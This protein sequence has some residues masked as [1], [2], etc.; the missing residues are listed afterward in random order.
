MFKEK[1]L[2]VFS[3][4]THIA[5]GQNLTAQ[6]IRDAL[7]ASLR[8][9]DI[10]ASLELDQV[11]L[12]GLIGGMTV[13]CVAVRHPEHT[14]DYFNFLVAV[15]PR[16]TGSF[17]TVYNG[18][19]SKQLKKLE[20]AAAAK[21]GA[22]SVGKSALHSVFNYDDSISGMFTSSAGLAKGAVGLARSIAKGVGAIGS[23]RKK[24]EIEQEWY[25]MV[26]SALSELGI[27]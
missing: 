18:G 19:Q 3:P 26:S 1:D 25:F 13:D 21:A 12:G 22:M 23:S 11:R 4:K 14:R 15:E 27:C 5:N 17:V 16:N 24:Q 9:H 20:S 7:A 2:S 6:D 10:P 8:E